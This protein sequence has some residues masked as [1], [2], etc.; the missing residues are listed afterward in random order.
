MDPDP[1]PSVTVIKICPFS[2]NFRDRAQWWISWLGLIIGLLVALAYHAGR[3]PEADSLPAFY[4][5][6][7]S[8][9]YDYI[10]YRAALM[11]FTEVVTRGL[12]YT[13]FRVGLGPI[14]STVLVLGLHTY[15]NWGTISPSLYC[16]LCFVSLK[17][18]LCALREWNGTI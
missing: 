1:L 6:G 14:C 18:V 8:S 9:R 12:I 3:I 4:D 7:V 11:P 13:R 16:F 10:I 15:F 17:I 5:S 2:L